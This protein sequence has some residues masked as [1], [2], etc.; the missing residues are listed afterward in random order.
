MRGGNRAVC[1]KGHHKGSRGFEYF[2]RPG[3][4]KGGGHGR[5][6]AG[7]IFADG[8]GEKYRQSLWRQG[9]FTC[10]GIAVPP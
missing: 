3:E 8:A 6:K 1:K 4:L 5:E 10:S 2:K 9:D 7:K